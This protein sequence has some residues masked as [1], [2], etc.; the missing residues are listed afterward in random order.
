MSQFCCPLI[1]ILCTI[2]QKISADDKVLMLSFPPLKTFSRKKTKTKLLYH[3]ILIITDVLWI[4]IQCHVI[5]IK[6][7]YFFKLT[8]VAHANSCLSKLQH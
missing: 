4:I 1:Q 8:N 3:S 2:V 5:L 7:D 6:M